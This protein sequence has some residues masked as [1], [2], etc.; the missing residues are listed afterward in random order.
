MKQ[1]ALLAEAGIDFM[2]ISGGSYED[3]KMMGRGKADPAAAPK[4]ARTA[5][6]EAFFL[7]FSKEVRERHPGL[8]LMLTG[9]FRTRAG[10]EAAIKDGAC[11]LVGIGRPG[12]IDPRFPRLLLDESVGDDEARMVL[13]NVAVPWYM[14]FLPLHLVGAGAESVSSFLSV[15]RLSG[16]SGLLTS[17]IDV[18]FWADSESGQGDCY[19]CTSVDFFYFILVHI[20]FSIIIFLDLE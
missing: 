16:L 17:F 8:V 19:Y 10:A 4:S 3:P 1:I 6:R 15:Y 12:A 18:L 2:E 14:R 11:D 5:A 13:N 9:G 20:C 7:E